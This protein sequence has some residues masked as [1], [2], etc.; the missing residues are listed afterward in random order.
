MPP[1]DVQAKIDKNLEKIKHRLLVFSGKG[2]VGK[3]TVAANLAVALA[4]Q[5]NRVGLLDVDI[6]GPN[7]AKMLGVEGARLKL[8]VKA[9]SLFP[10][11]KI[12]IS[13][14]WLFCSKTPTFRSFGEAP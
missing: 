5:G 10:S 7:L 4:Q 8:R 6:H 2:G 11:T 3:S 12:S 13:S 9:S 1:E 14:P